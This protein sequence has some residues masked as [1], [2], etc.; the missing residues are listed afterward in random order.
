MRFK[1]RLALRRWRPQQP[2]RQ[3]P[4]RR[5]P[6][7]GRGRTCVSGFYRDGQADG[8]CRGPPAG[9]PSSIGVLCAARARQRPP[10]A[11]ALAKL[12]GQCASRARARRQYGGRQIRQDPQLLPPLLRKYCSVVAG[13]IRI[14]SDEIRSK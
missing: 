5:S 4:R 8:V 7:D 13:S 3:R 9:A 2:R 1:R 10:G 12:G 14:H 11:A 6:D